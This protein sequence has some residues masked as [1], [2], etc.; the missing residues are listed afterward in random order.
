MKLRTVN[1]A[2]L[3]LGRKACCCALFWSGKP[4]VKSTSLR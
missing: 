1:D 3:Q 4:A 2:G